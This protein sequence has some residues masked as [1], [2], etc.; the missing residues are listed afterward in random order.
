[1]ITLKGNPCQ[2]GQK[3]GKVCAEK[4]REDLSVLVWRE[5]YE[6]LPRGDADFIAWRKK[7]ESILNRNWPWLLE[8]MTGVA[9]AMDTSFE[10]VLLLNLRAWQY[11]YYGEPP[12]NACS[13][14]AISLDDGTVACAG[15]LDGSC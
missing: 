14:L 10:D 13:S 4:I 15:T 8:E 12:G 9:E 5:G 6:P 1:L 2:I 7:Q 11:N 3:Y